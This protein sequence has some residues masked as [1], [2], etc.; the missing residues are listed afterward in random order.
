[1]ATEDVKKLGSGAV[2]YILTPQND[3]GHPPPPLPCIFFGIKMVIVREKKH[4]LSNI[5]L[6]LI[7]GVI[8]VTLAIV[9]IPID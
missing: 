9:F 3:S 5:D 1:L 8:F 2:R 6:L 4:K 7:V